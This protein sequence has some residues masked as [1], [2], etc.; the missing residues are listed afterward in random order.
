MQLFFESRVHIPP[1][2]SHSC[3]SFSASENVPRLRD[4]SL[5]AISIT[6]PGSSSPKASSNKSF[7]YI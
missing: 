6:T 4:G 7:F 3:P 2:N 1:L 5:L